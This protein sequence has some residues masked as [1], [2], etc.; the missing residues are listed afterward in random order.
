MITT[1]TFVAL[2]EQYFRS[3]LEK[4]VEEKRVT[5]FQEETRQM[6]YMKG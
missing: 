1:E 2:C 4:I 6:N 3:F 5:H